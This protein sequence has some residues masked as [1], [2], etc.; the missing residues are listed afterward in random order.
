MWSSLLDFNLKNHC[1]EAENS[2]FVTLAWLHFFPEYSFIFFTSCTFKCIANR[3]LVLNLQPMCSIILLW[4]FYMVSF[5]SVHWFIFR[6]KYLAKSKE[7][8]LVLLTWLSARGIYR[9][10]TW[11]LIDRDISVKLKHYKSRKFLL[12]VNTFKCKITWA[13]NL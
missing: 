9:C 3:C 1:P 11:W 10:V 6:S 7:G 12:V 5:V 2:Y 4:F 13:K 8:Q